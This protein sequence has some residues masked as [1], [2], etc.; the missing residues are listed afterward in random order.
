[1]AKDWSGLFISS[2]SHDA[3]EFIDPRDREPCPVCGRYMKAQE[4]PTTEALDG[5]CYYL[6]CTC[7]LTY[8]H[9]T[10]NMTLDFYEDLEKTWDLWDSGISEQRKKWLKKPQ[11]PEVSFDISAGRN[12]SCIVCDTEL[13]EGYGPA[14]GE[15]DK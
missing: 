3:H 7:G 6:K 2:I 14:C 10:K 8:R 15:C 5:Y 4:L 11:T 13:T 12:G 9:A 1:M